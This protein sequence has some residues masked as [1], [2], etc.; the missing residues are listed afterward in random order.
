MKLKNLET[1][2]NLIETFRYNAFIYVKRDEN[3]MFI[4]TEFTL[5]QNRHH[6]R[7]EG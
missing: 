2:L 3:F 1:L 6:K 5:L 4:S 7:I